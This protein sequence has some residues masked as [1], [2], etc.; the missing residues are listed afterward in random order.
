MQVHSSKNRVKEN[1]WEKMLILKAPNKLNRLFQA[2][3]ETQITGFVLGLYSLTI[4][5]NILGL[6]IDLESNTTSNWLSPVR[7]GL[8]FSLENS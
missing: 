5:K 8:T 6:V 1:T 7:S 2:R 4:L 3:N